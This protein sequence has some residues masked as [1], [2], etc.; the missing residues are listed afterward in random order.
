MIMQVDVICE[1]VMVLGEGPL[2]HP[3]E[4]VLYWVDIIG[5]TIYCLDINSGV[6]S[7]MKLSSQVGSIGWCE[8]GGLVAALSNSFAW[9][10]V[11]AHKTKTIID[12]VG[13][14]GKT[15]LN[16]GKCDRQGRFWVGSKDLQEQNA[17]GVIYRLDI[18]GE[19]TRMTDGF[20]VSNGL[21]WS[22]DNKKM[23]ICDSPMRIIYQYDFDL[24]TGRLGERS[25]FAKIKEKEGFPDGLTVDSEG[26]VWNCHWDGWQITRYKPSGEVDG[27]IPLPV[28]RP[29]SCCFGGPELNILYVTSASVGLSASK[30]ADSPLAGKVLALD[31]GIKG[32]PESPYLGTIKDKVC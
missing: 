2:W 14:S 27:I 23:Y 19:V 11:H 25:V 3:R 6:L 13:D 5:A 17:H 26:C 28:E 18:D 20:T 1:E 16:D 9:V 32:L 21:A 22:P 8:Q 10:D 7:E 30:L 15:M 24:T 4:S 31:V 29:T 12:H